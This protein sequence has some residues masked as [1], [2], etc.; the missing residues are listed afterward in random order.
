VMVITQWPQEIL[1]IEN[2]LRCMGKS[3]L[4]LQMMIGC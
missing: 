2:V 1:G 4:V 3:L